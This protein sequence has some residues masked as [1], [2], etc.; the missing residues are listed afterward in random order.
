MLDEVESEALSVGKGQPGL[1][2]FAGLGSD[3]WPP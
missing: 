2:T 3:S 1:V